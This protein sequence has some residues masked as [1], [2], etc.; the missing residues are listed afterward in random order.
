MLVTCLQVEGPPPTAKSSIVRKQLP[1]ELSAERRTPRKLNVP[2]TPRTPTPNGPTRRPA[3]KANGNTP[4]KRPVLTNGTALQPA[5]AANVPPSQPAM[6][7]AGGPRKVA[8]PSV[9]DASSQNGGPRKL[10][11]TPAKPPA[12]GSS[13]L[14]K[15]GNKPPEVNGGGSSVASGPRELSQNVNGMVQ[16]WNNGVNGVSGKGSG[17]RSVSEGSQSQSQ[18]G[19]PHELAVRKAHP[20][21]LRRASG[22]NGV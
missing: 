1:A 22:V 9:A 20:P 12:T 7:V 19:A 15:R 11:Q 3:V 6:I 8:P 13:V 17:G 5:K 21:K 4:V 18:A 10:S 2:D 16:Q 14:G